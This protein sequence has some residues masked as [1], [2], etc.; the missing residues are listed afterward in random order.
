MPVVMFDL[1]GTLIEEDDYDYNRA[2]RWMADTYFDDRFEELQKLSCLFKANYMHMRA[3]SSVESSFRAQLVFFEKAL[4][5]KLQDSYQIVEAEF[6]RRFRKEKLKDG[7]ISLLR[8]L[9]DCKIRIYVLTNS[10]F[11]GENLK[12]HLASVGIEDVVEAV[13]SSADI[14][15]RKPSQEVFQYVLADI[16]VR[17]SSQVVY[18]G[19]SYEKDYLGAQTSGLHSILVTSSPDYANIAL[20]NLFSLESYLKACVEY[21]VVAAPLMRHVVL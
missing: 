6:I 16:G 8:M 21:H 2:L 13:Y 12:A 14:G 5:Y 18:I 20:P 17:D 9:H 1:Y 11:S 7:A 3:V 19:D 4:N 15:Y 10:L